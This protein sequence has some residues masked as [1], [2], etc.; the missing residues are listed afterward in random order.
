LLII[1][2][3]QNKIFHKRTLLHFTLK[4]SAWQFSG[5]KW[6]LKSFRHH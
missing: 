2:E 5:I 1:S 3:L 4:F 6:G